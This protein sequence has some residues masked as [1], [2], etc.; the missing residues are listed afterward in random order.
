MSHR[1]A[2]LEQAGLRTPAHGCVPAGE[3]GQGRR[4]ALALLV[5]VSLVGCGTGGDS[6]TTDP[7]APPAGPA[8]TVPDDGSAN[9]TTPSGEGAG[10]GPAPDGSST[11]EVPADGPD[12][13]GG[14]PFEVT[15]TLAG[16]ASS[17]TDDLWL[18]HQLR[19]DQGTFALEFADSGYQVVANEVPV[20]LEITD[21][22]TGEPV[23]GLGADVVVEGIRHPDPIPVGG[24]SFP[25]E[26]VTG[27]LW[28]SHIE[29]VG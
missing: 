27:Y 16:V 1:A 3:K 20:Q 4:L 15:G 13:A 2:T 12:I 23:A 6:A 18:C 8:T 5:T 7:T 28:V 17:P 11:T 9:P 26:G 22:E 19:T 21:A 25:C 10:G 14:E 29:L 24:L